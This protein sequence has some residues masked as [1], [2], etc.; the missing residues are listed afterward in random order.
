MKKSVSFAVALL[1]AG[2][3]TLAAAQFSAE[4]NNLTRNT[5][6][7]SVMPAQP[8]T[9]PVPPMV[10]TPRMAGNVPL[11]S[12]DSAGCWGADGSR[13]TRA[14]NTLFSS[15]GRTCYMVA[16]NAPAMCN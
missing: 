5:D 2:S 9:E 6:W 11:N 1:L 3:A 16:P 4:G 8:A 12:C 10:D 7:N 13:Y 15:N 14:G